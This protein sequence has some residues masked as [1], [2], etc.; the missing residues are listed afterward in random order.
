MDTEKLT[1]FIKEVKENPDKYI[2]YLKENPDKYI[3]YLEENHGLKLY[4]Y[5]KVMLKNILKDRKEDIY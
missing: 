1:E 4:W 5:Q 2:E 3:E